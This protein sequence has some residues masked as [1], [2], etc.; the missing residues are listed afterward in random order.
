MDNGCGYWVVVGFDCLFGGGNDFFG[1]CVGVFGI[2][3]WFNCD[4]VLVGC[5]VV[6]VVKG[7]YCCYVGGVNF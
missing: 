2:Y 7:G 1:N 4:Y 6:R 3:W 5:N